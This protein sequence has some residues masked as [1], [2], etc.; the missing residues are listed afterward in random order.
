MY[1]EGTLVSM[2]SQ[3]TIGLRLL[4]IT[5][6]QWGERI[7]AFIKEQAPSDWEVHI[8]ASAR[9]LP[10]VI[11]D[12]DEFLP[13]AFPPAD[14]VLSLGETGGLA[15]LIPDIV[16]RSGAQAVIAPIDRN[17]SLPEG[18]ANQ[19]Q[20][21]LE[22]DG[23]AVI[24]PKPFCTLTE[25]TYNRFPRVTSYDNDLIRRFARHFGRPSF[26]VEVANEHITQVRVLRQAACGCAQ[27]V[28]Q[29]LPGTPLAEALESAGMLHHHFPCLAS[30][31]QDI[32]YNDTLMHVSGNEL[33]EALKAELEAYL[34]KTYL[35]PTGFSEES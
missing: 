4:A 20:R 13:A 27:Y 3:P 31:N 5:Q 15:Q 24:F 1:K 19:L 12:P 28:A 35:R 11:D 23:V 9:V 25:T 29:H 34:P 14:L 16:R 26:A 8:W 2:P 33:K 10:V 17:E 18:L 22:Q 30:M 21:W 32:D 6:G 7:A